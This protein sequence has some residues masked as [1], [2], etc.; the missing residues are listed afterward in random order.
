MGLSLGLRGFGVIVPDASVPRGPMLMQGTRWT[1]PSSNW[2]GLDNFIPY[3]RIPKV[4]D[5]N[6]R[7]FNPK[8]AGYSL[9]AGQAERQLGKPRP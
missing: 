6:D 2:V 3:C 7:S 9:R 5:P 4:V 1:H 8:S